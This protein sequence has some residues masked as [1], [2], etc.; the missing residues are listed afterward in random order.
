MKRVRRISPIE[1]RRLQ[2]LAKP[3]DDGFERLQDCA[4]QHAELKASHDIHA[5]KYL[6]FGASL[7]KKHGVKP[8]EEIDKVT[9]EIRKVTAKG[10][11]S[12]VKK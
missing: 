2:D 10:P 8:D 3:V 1:L 4:L 7:V 5:T 11:A 9:G 12:V 6:R